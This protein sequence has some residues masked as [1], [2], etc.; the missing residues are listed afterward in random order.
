MTHPTTPPPAAAGIVEKLARALY[1]ESTTDPLGRPGREHLPYRAGYWERLAR[2][3]IAMLAAE[4]PE[5]GHE[6]AQCGPDEGD[7]CV[8]CGVDDSRST[9]PCAL[10][11]G[12]VAIL[13]ALTAARARV[14][15]LEAEVARLKRQY[16]AKE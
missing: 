6:W 13:A 11:D 12:T 9:E 16:E 15:E 5:A 4:A 3:A 1:A 10:D 2:A 7:V 14:A 8:R